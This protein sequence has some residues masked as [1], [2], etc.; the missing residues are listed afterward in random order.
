MGMDAARYD[1]DGRWG[2]EP[3]VVPEHLD[4]LGVLRELEWTSQMKSRDT[5]SMGIPYNYAGASYPEVPFHPV[6][7]R[8]AEL[9]EARLGFRATNALLN[10]YP[11]GEHTIGW[12]VDD[13]DILAPGT[14]IAIL[15]FGGPR[16]MLLRS[17]AAPDFDYIRLPLASGSLLWMTAELQATHKHAMKREPGA[18]ERISVT[19]RHLTHAPPPVTTPKW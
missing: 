9:V 7:A 16:T 19:L 2:Y 12:H 10:R 13:V 15:S 8:L 6:V 11:T 18:A 17:G 3:D 14:G 5:A 4:V 1:P